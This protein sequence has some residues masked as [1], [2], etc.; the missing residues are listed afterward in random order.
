VQNKVTSILFD[1]KRIVHK[2]FIQASQAVN[3]EH[4]CEKFYDDYMK[5]CEHFAPDFG[6]KRTGCCITTTHRPT[7]TSSLP[8]IFFYQK[9][10]DY[11][12]PTTTLFS[13][14]SIEDKIE[15]PPF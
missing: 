10:H 9:Q 8:G 7:H 13:V 12:P 11:L 14:S 2:E 3:S 1:V 6:D 5:M 4:Y 15:R